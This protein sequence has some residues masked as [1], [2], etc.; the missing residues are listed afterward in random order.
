MIISNARLLRISAELVS[1][2]NTLDSF[3][4]IDRYVFYLEK[5]YAARDV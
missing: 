5:T 4:F 3:V 2:A 1:A